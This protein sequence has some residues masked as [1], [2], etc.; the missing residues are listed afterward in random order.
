MSYEIRYF[1]RPVVPD[2]ADRIAETDRFEIEELQD[3]LLEVTTSQGTV[4]L[5]I[6]KRGAAE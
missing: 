5:H 2:A 6:G 3:N 4:Y 1:L